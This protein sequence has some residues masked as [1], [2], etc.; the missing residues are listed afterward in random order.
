MM[1]RDRRRA[2][3]FGADL[4]QKLQ[5]LK[6]FYEPWLEAGQPGF[7]AL[8]GGPNPKD[9]YVNLFGTGTSTRDSCLAT[10]HQI[11]GAEAP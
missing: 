2:N 10:V 11:P 1:Q 7:E 8:A 3:E 9:Y 6:Q 5:D 4:S